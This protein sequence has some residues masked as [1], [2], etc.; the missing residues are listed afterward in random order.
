MD[1][2]IGAVIFF[3]A[4]LILGAASFWYEPPLS[5]SYTEMKFTFPHVQDWGLL[6]ISLFCLVCL[7]LILRWN[8]R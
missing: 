1:K 5:E 3:F 7:I 2:R 4:F 8:K 6:F